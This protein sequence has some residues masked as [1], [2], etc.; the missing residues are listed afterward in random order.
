MSQL[1]FAGCVF[2]LKL[3]YFFVSFS[4]FIQY[5]D[6][7]YTKQWKIRA[8]ATHNIPIMI[9]WCRIHHAQEM[10]LKSLT[11]KLG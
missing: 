6:I 2:I 11:Y 7:I 9:I 1:S 5:N 10:K 4:I 3:Q 8:K